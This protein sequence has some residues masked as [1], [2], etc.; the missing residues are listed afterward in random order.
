MKAWDASGLRGLIDG[1]SKLDPA[2]RTKEKAAQA[3]EALTAGANQACND[4]GRGQSEVLEAR[5]LALRIAEAAFGADA[6]DT[7]YPRRTLA[8]DLAGAGDWTAADALLEED[9]ARVEARGDVRETAGAVYSLANHRVRGGDAEPLVARLRDLT[10]ADARVRDDFELLLAHLEGALAG[11]DLA[12]EEAA[13]KAMVDSMRRAVGTRHV[14]YAIAVLQLGVFYTNIDRLDEAAH[15]LAIARDVARG[16]EIEGW[17]LRALADLE[18]A[19]GRF[20]DALT[21]LDAV[22]RL[23]KHKYDA[24]RDELEAQR[25]RIASRVSTGPTR[26]RHPKIGVGEVIAREG[27]R[28]R[29]R[30]EDGSERT[31][32]A[33]RLEPV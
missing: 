19:R 32:L 13:A 28:V 33:D 7:S 5:R 22:D 8:S 24:P 11:G 31:F 23:W 30:M 2:Q 16:T 21:L 6:Q 15:A 14:D 9:L 1:W 4:G 25:Q 18:E 20:A 3:V 10:K 29:L 12:R 26:M 27:D 17:V